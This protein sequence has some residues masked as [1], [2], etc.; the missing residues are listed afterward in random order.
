LN[1]QDWIILYLSISLLVIQ[2]LWVKDIRQAEYQRGRA[3]VLEVMAEQ[4]EQGP[5]IAPKKGHTK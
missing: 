1:K 5:Y 2:F 4:V 3:E